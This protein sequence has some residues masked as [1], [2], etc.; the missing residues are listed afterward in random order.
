MFHSLLYVI[1]I[2]KIR[3]CSFLV[4]EDFKYRSIEPV[5][6]RNQENNINN[7]HEP[8]CTLTQHWLVFVF[9]VVVQFWNR[10]VLSLR[11]LFYKENKPSQSSIFLKI[12]AYLFFQPNILGYYYLVLLIYCIF[13]FKF[14]KSWS[15][16]SRSYP[17]YQHG[18]QAKLHVNT[19]S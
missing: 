3:L 19:R 9:L 8:G 6:I 13:Q 5:T 10:F 4:S 15:H 18:I 11:R 1:A 14:S 2:R 17:T 12:Y 7:F 16:K